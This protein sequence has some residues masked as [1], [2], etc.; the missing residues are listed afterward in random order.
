MMRLPQQL[1]TKHDIAH[2]ID[3]GTL[4]GMVRHNGSLI[5]WEYDAD[6]ALMIEDFNKLISL[7]AEA[8]QSGL[9][10][11]C[12]SFFADTAADCYLIVVGGFHLVQ[13]SNSFARMFVSEH[14]GIYV[15]IYANEV[16]SYDGNV[17]NVASGHVDPFPLAFIQ[18]L[19]LV[20]FEGGVL[21]APNNPEGLLDLRY[22]SDWRH[23][24]KRQAY[25]V[26]HVCNSSTTSMEHA[27]ACM[28]CASRVGALLTSSLK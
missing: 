16:S 5:P 18:P 24:F 4:L 28:H 17:Y 10:Q 15:D 26:S 25:E 6:I 8:K 21:P 2:W 27:Q 1:L 14:N 13:V 23:V 7:K 19:V 3:Y 22:G 20:H 12:C 11:N 9:G